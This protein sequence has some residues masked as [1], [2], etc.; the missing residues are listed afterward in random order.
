[1]ECLSLCWGTLAI[2]ANKSEA[3]TG[4]SNL[5]GTCTIPVH[6]NQRRPV[7]FG[8]QTTFQQTLEAGIEL[9][10]PGAKEKVIKDVSIVTWFQQITSEMT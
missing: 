4:G 3:F 6:A 7:K 9:K 10:L 5:I 1:M 2:E 8:D